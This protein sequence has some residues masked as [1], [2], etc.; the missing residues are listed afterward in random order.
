MIEQTVAIMQG[1]QSNIH[2]YRRLLETKLNEIEREYLERRL[3]EELAAV[4][5]R[6]PQLRAEMCDRAET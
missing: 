6:L 2:R 4:E 5:P 1:H 3:S